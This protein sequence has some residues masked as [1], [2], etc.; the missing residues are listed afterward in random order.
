[1]VKTHCA[2][3]RGAGS[4]QAAQ[5]S[6]AGRAVQAAR[7]GTGRAPA[8][9]TIASL[10]P[11]K[12]IEFL[13]APR[14]LD[15]MAK[16][17]SEQIQVLKPFLTCGTWP[18]VN[19][20]DPLLQSSRR[21]QKETT[22]KRRKAFWAKPRCWHTAR[23]MDDLHHDTRP[24]H[25]NWE[26]SRLRC[27]EPSSKLWP[28]TSDL[29]L[30]LSRLLV[31]SLFSSRSLV[32][33]LLLGSCIF[34]V[35]LLPLASL[36]CSTLVLARSRRFCEL[37][38]RPARSSSCTGFW[39]TVVSKTKLPVDKTSVNHGAPS[40]QCPR[41]TPPRATGFARWFRLKTRTLENQS[42]GKGLQQECLTLCSYSGPQCATCFHCV[43]TPQTRTMLPPSTKR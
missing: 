8:L 14:I 10:T 5:P 30:F 34:F 18:S 29:S 9:G 11:Q 2:E 6:A 22:K 32:L 40:A 15:V 33:G 7:L 41:F 19:V 31:A 43:H 25:R 24:A 35:A 20:R 26:P 28:G 38:A 36:L 3:I 39:Y 1:M 17:D 13:E 37:G 16:E 27:Q 12:R 4:T 21:K 42:P 23:L